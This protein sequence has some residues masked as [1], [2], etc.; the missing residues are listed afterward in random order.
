MTNL[1]SNLLYKVFEF[2]EHIR[3]LT[4]ID[5]DTFIVNIIYHKVKKLQIVL[6]EPIF[7]SCKL[8]S[9]LILTCNISHKNIIFLL[10]IDIQIYYQ[11][12]FELYENLC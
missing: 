11:G 4:C 7:L 8:N 1:F 9:F 12:S 10:E 5:K 3:N 2:L 6:T